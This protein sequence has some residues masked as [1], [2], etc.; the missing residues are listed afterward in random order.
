MPFRQAFL[1]PDPFP[2]AAYVKLRFTYRLSLTGNAT[3]TLVGSSYVLQLNSIFEPLDTAAA[4]PYGH[5]QMIA[6]YGRYK[7]KDVDVA[8][9]HGAP[10]ALG[11]V[12]TLAAQPPEGGQTIVGA[13][14]SLIGARPNV[15]SVFVPYLGATGPDMW[16]RKYNIAELLGLTQ[17]EYDANVEE[18]SAAVG[19]NP[20]RMPTLEI[21]GWN[22]AGSG[23]VSTSIFLSMIFTVQFFGRVGQ[24][25]S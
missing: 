8:I 25:N 11:N 19:T 6:L 1:G 21:G 23:S 13:D 24:A 16:R 3:P 10:V 4:Q 2:S 20:G 14:G 18:Y 9:T 17:Q 7:V 22:F 15:A 12:L 5:D